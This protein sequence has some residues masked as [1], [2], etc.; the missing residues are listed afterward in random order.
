MCDTNNSIIKAI[1]LN[2]NGINSNKSTASFSL[3][4]RSFYISPYTV[5]FLQE[6]RLKLDRADELSNLCNWPNSKVQAYFTSNERGNGGVATI[7]K[8]TFTQSI[9]TQTSA[10]TSRSP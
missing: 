1:W 6:P 9:E 10:S 5:M 4:L 7:F 3:L 2:T 8:K